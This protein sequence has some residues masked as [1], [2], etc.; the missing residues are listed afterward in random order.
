M[1]RQS[2]EIG[3]VSLQILGSDLAGNGFIVNM[4]D[5]LHRTLNFEL[6]PLIMF[7]Y[8]SFTLFQILYSRPINQNTSTKPH[9]PIVINRQPSAIDINQLGHKRTTISLHFDDTISVNIT[10]QMPHMEWKPHLVQWHMLSVQIQPSVT[11]MDAPI[12]ILNCEDM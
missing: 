6:Q 2:P 3:H 10:I 11:S 5:D 1:H 12:T 9:P 7:I 4:F 8:L